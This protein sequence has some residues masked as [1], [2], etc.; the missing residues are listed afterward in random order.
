M[1]SRLHGSTL[2]VVGPDSCGISILAPPVRPLIH[3]PVLG[4]ARFFR[5]RF[6]WLPVTVGSGHVGA[7]TNWNALFRSHLADTRPRLRPSFARGSR[8]VAP[9]ILP[10]G[11]APR[12]GAA[13]PRTAARIAYRQ[14][15]SPPSA[16]AASRCMSDRLCERTTARSDRYDFRAFFAVP[17]VSVGRFVHELD[18]TRYNSRPHLHSYI[19]DGGSQVSS[20]LGIPP[21]FLIDYRLKAG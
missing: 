6:F 4:M 10:A 18:S 19:S 9:A 1:T 16:A 2:R 7:R 17:A 13:C 5:C 3:P 8:S 11:A 14:Y 21:G 12:A 15:S 20:R